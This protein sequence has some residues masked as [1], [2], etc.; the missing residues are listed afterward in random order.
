[1]IEIAF[2]FSRGRLRS[3]LSSQRKC[4]AL[5]LHHYSGGGPPSTCAVGVGASVL[6]GLSWPCCLPCW[7]WTSQFHGAS[8]HRL[9]SCPSLS[10][11]PLWV[12]WES[13]GRGKGN[14]L[15]T[16][17]WTWICSWTWVPDLSPLRSR[18]FVFFF[19]LTLLR[20][21]LFSFYVDHFKVFIEFVTIMLLFCVSGFLTTR[22]EG[23]LFPSPGN[24][25]TPALKVQSL[26][27]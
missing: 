11:E 27:H 5:P 10:C 18:C 6:E 24:N 15:Q 17:S 22:N 3:T 14:I 16:R 9:A 23:S 4:L 26:N 8:K 12:W 19:N 13:S 21:L 25:H 1:M 20:L 7:P 2:Y